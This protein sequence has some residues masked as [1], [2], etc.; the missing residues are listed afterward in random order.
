MTKDDKIKA[1]LN[2][3]DDV[4]KK[5]KERTPGEWQAEFVDVPDIDY[6]PERVTSPSADTTDNRNKV[7][8]FG[9]GSDYHRHSNTNASF[10]ASASVSH[11][12]NARAL[13]EVIEHLTA[14]QFDDTDVPSIALESILSIYPEEILKHYL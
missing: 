2:L 8:T 1:L 12:R 5:D 14:N 6:W 3:L 9:E 4:I 10:I 11:G 13:K 7:C